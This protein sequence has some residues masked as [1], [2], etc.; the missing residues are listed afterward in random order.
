MT[1]RYDSI[2]HS[3]QM[4]LTSKR[5]LNI[6]SIEHLIWLNISLSLSLSE[7]LTT[8]ETLIDSKIGN[9]K[10]QIVPLNSQTAANSWQLF[11]FVNLHIGFCY[12]T[13]QMLHIQMKLSHFA[14]N[15]FFFFPFILSMRKI[16]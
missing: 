4:K 14:G 9:S 12:F 13:N 8:N 11:H 10:T 16:V 3:Q 15:F 6:Y 1:L 5:D 2:V 7:S